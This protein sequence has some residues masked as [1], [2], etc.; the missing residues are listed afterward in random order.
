MSAFVSWS[1][2]KDCMYAMHRFLL[3]SELPVSHLVNMCDETGLKSGSHGLDSALIKAQAEQLN[4]ELVQK[5][6]S[7]SQYRANFIETISKLKNEGVTTGIFGDIYLEAHR[8]WIEE[9]CTE[10]GVTP[11][12]PLWGMDTS[13]LPDLFVADGYKSMVV[14]VR[15]EKLGEEWL[16]RIIDEKFV[17][18]IKS[19]T[20]IDPCAEQGEYHTFVL[21]GPLFNKAVEYNINEKWEDE[22]HLYLELKAITA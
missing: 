20:E 17:E 7:K 5:P 15:K 14:A 2:G 21:D 6:T 11:V 4:V 13:E 8:E 10:I 1:G 12:F 19:L 16:G 3:Q 9:V 18:D 22:C